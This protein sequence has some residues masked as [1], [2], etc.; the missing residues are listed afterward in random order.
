MALDLP[1][2][3]S[4]LSVPRMSEGVDPAIDLAND[5]AIPAIDLANDLATPAIHRG[6]PSTIHRAIPLP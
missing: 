6:I 3:A 5:L 2:S 1:G 4:S